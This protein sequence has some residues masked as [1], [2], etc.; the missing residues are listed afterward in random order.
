MMDRSALAQLWWQLMQIPAAQFFAGQPERMVVGASPHGTTMS[1]GYVGRDYDLGGWLLVGNYPAGGT[2]SYIERPNPTDQR[3]YGSFISLAAADTDETRLARFEAMS[4]TWIE[5]QR[6]HRIYRTLFLPLFRAGGKTDQDVAFLNAFPFRCRD[7]KAP[8][9]GMYT[10]AWKLAV[11]RQVEA[12]QPGKII[13]LGVAA[14]RAIER[15]LHGS[16]DLVV[17]ERS[18]GDRYLK[19]SAQRVMEALA[20]EAGNPRHALRQEPVPEKAEPRQPSSA[21]ATNAVRVTITTV[22]ASRSVLSS[23]RSRER[24]QSDPHE[25]NDTGIHDA[26]TRSH[27]SAS[28]RHGG[29]GP[30]PRH[31]GHGWHDR[32]PDLQRTHDRGD[33]GGLPVPGA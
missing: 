27:Y 33:P 25:S 18:N 22:G 20:R 17:L 28:G 10:T 8:T 3:L 9:M 19:D 23:N 29:K 24:A 21:G 7:N 32:G 26:R 16:A 1:P 30:H 5:L 2:A 15:F 12:L 11:S 14:G 13:A 6:T 31:A 4:A